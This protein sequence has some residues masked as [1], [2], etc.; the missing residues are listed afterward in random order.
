M[1]IWI[2]QRDEEYLEHHGIKGQKWGVR[3]YTN[4]DGTLTDEGLKKYRKNDNEY[5]YPKTKEDFIGILKYDRDHNNKQRYFQMGDGHIQLIHH[6]KDKKGNI[7]LSY[8]YL[9]QFGNIYVKG[10]GNLGDLDLNKLFK[11]SPSEKDFIN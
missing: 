2:I 11:K 8:A 7:A 9:P 1:G 10:N 4:E 3:R 5:R 6:F